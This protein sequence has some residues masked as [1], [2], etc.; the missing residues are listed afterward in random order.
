VGISL[1]AR[2]KL[3]AIK[4]TILLEKKFQQK[5]AKKKEKLRGH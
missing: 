1:I 3:A 2:N 5:Q 4:V